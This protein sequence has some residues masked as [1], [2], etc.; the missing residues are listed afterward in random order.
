MP[1][2]SQVG[3]VAYIMTLIEELP[4]LAPLFEGLI[5]RID[6]ASRYQFSKMGSPERVTVLK[7]LEEQH[8]DVFKVL[9]DFTY[10]SY[11]TNESVFP[12]IGYEPHPTGSTGPKM[13]PFDDA[14]LDRV[15]QSAPFYTKI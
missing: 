12:L 3:G 11:Y 14:L 2:A 5:A 4:E 15:K 10:E 9:K 7:A 1:S 6:E 13:E 8:P